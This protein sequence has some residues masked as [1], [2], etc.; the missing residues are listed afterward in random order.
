MELLLVTCVLVFVCSVESMIVPS[1]GF[2]PVEFVVVG[3]GAV[4]SFAASQVR[5]TEVRATEVRVSQVRLLQVRA[6]FNL[7]PVYFHTNTLL[8]GVATLLGPV[9]GVVMLT[10]EDEAGAGGG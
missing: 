5:A 6:R 2:A 9:Y 10:T 4:I 1:V 3:L 7:V 8:V